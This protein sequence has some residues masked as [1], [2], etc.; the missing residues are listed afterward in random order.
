MDRQHSS[1]L[2]QYGPPYNS[3]DLEVS[4]APQV[5]SPEKSVVISQDNQSA[6]DT[7]GLFYLIGK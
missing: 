4:G 2:H 5:S 7:K 1:I 6:F 3:G